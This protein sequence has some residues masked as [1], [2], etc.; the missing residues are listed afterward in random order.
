MVTR[1][2]RRTLSGLTSAFAP[3]SKSKQPVA[4]TVKSA[5]QRGDEAWRRTTHGVHNS[6]LRKDPKA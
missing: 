2:V 1:T 4:Y 5:Q 3:A 6:L